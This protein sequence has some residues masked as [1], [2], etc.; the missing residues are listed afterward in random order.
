MNINLIYPK[1]PAP[2]DRHIPGTAITACQILNTLTEQIKLQLQQYAKDTP[3]ASVRII[4]SPIEQLI[5]RLT[6]QARTQ[7][8][9][10]NL[11]IILQLGASAQD[12]HWH[13]ASGF[14]VTSQPDN[15]QSDHLSDLLILQALKILGRSAISNQTAAIS[16]RE[17]SAARLLDVSASPAVLTT[18]LYIDNRQNAVLLRQSGGIRMLA[19]VYA[20]AIAEYLKLSQ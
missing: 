10:A 20:Q 8:P 5:R 1:I 7:A 18:C 14:T 15:P 12:G 13:T 9:S 16:Q 17:H 19:S 4:T 2:L 11:N 6:R 3:S